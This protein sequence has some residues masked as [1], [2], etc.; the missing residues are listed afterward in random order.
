MLKEM[1][2]DLAVIK[3]GFRL[4]IMRKFIQNE[5]FQNGSS[6]IMLLRTRKYVY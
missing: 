2:L 6:F 3:E 1:N 4:H 5:L